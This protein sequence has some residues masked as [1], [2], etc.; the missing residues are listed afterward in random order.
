VRHSQLWCIVLSGE[1]SLR[2]CSLAPF[3]GVAPRRVEDSTLNRGVQKSG[4]GAAM[5]YT[6]ST[7]RDSRGGR[8]VSGRR[9]RDLRPRL[10][11]GNV[12]R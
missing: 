4:N 8:R 7:G 12:S 11:L 6:V 2:I 5:D 3:D 10:D 1:Y 9:S